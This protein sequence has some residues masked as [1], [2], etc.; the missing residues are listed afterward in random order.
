M[1]T[2]S[3]ALKESPLFLVCNRYF[4]KQF[5]LAEESRLP[6]FLHCRNSHQ[7]FIGGFLLQ[8][9][10]CMRGTLYTITLPSICLCFDRNHEEESGQMCWRSGEDTV[11]Y[12]YSKRVFIGHLRGEM[13]RQRGGRYWQVSACSGFEPAY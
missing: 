4:E 13:E 3:T 6:M 10:C 11:L 5:E 12:F 2:I 8:E 7:E 9:V 1:I